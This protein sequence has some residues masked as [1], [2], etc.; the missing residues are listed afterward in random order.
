MPFNSPTVRTAAADADAEAF[1]QHLVDESVRILNNTDDAARLAKFR[2]FIGKFADASKAAAFTLGA[3]RRSA[4]DSDV[5]AFTHAFKDYVSAVYETRLVRLKGQTLK[6]VGSIDN[7]PGDVTVNTVLVDPGAAEP[8]RVAFRLLGSRGNYRFVDI[9][10]A[11][12]W[13]S[14]DQ[15]DQFAALLSRKGGSVPALTADLTA[16]AQQLRA[17]MAPATTH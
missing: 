14:V 12:V 15:R 1:A 16:Q 2:A 8:L 10:V 7:K 17:S 11:G 4:S 13:L 3:H 5:A 6:V 9:Q